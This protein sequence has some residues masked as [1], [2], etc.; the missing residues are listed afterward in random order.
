MPADN[1]TTWPWKNSPVCLITGSAQGLGRAVA[2]ALARRGATVLLSARDPAKAAA[3]ATSLASGDSGEL[4]SLSD[5]LDVANQA[6][7]DTAA[8]AIQHGY[9]RLDLLINNAAA[10][11]DWAETAT[12]ADLSHSC[13]VMDTNLYGPWRMIQTMLPLLRQK[14]QPLQRWLSLTP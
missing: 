4:R 7:I 10:Y 9:G 13:S 14:R 8:A 5:G 11:A 2:E 3:A 1:D 6:S 12:T